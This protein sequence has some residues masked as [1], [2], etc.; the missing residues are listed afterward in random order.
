M[1]VGYEAREH[2]DYLELV[3]TGSYAPE[4][5]LQVAEEGLKRAA[6]AG[7]TALLIDIRSITG[8]EPTI[9]E[10]YDQ[11]VQVAN[12]QSRVT[13]RIRLALLGREPMIHPQRFGEIV[14]TNRGALLRSFTDEK[15][16][17]D[18]LL[19]QQASQARGVVRDSK[20]AGGI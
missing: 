11:A 8:R 18:W 12:L 2:A 20:I 4:I 13:P 17:L 15:L 10:R 6:R 16:A 3:C 7:R 9:S 5:P 1:S 14:A 19:G